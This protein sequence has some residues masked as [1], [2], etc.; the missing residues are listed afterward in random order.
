MPA[1]RFSLI[2]FSNAMRPVL[3]HPCLPFIEIVM[4]ID[5]LEMRVPV[6]LNLPLHH[7]VASGP[8]RAFTNHDFFHLWVRLLKSRSESLR[9]QGP[10]FRI[11]FRGRHTRI[12]K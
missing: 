1:T 5:S 3:P 11:R 12:P 2:H 4:Q 6:M 9:T 8:A 10:E 7:E